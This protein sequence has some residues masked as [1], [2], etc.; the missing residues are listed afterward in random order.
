MSASTSANIRLTTKPL[1][2]CFSSNTSAPAAR[3]IS[4]VLSVELLSKTK[5]VAAGRAARKSFTTLL[6]AA[7]SL[8]QGTSTAI[9]YGSKK[10]AP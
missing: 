1:P 2:R 6:I 3:A 10:P 5:T 4:A 7:S 9:R 8:K